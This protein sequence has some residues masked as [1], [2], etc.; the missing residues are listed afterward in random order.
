MTKREPL[1]VPTLGNHQVKVPMQTVAIHQE[2][3]V[4]ASLISSG[5]HWLCI[6]YLSPLHPTVL[7]VSCPV[8][9]APWNGKQFGT[10]NMVDH[11]VHFTC[12]PGFQ[13]IGSSS[14]VCQ[15]NGSWTGE[16]PQCKGMLSCY[17]LGLGTDASHQIIKQSHTQWR[18]IH[19]IW[20]HAIWI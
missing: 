15:S 20:I 10:K 11:E 1:G 8:L 9:D 7:A 13:L 16:V 17:S 2:G 14:R 3:P 12:D 19:P 18:Q 5:S 4:K 6:F